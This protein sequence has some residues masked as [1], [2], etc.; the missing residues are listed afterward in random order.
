MFKSITSC[1]LIA[2]AILS[3]T[4]VAAIPAV[5][6]SSPTPT[7]DRP[8]STSQIP[9][10]SQSTDIRSTDRAFQSLQTLVERYGC[11][12]DLNGD[13]S[14]SRD[15][16]VT[17]LNVC[18]NQIER[19]IITNRNSVQPAD[20][21][22]LR[23][24]QTEFGTELAALRDRLDAVEKKTE[25]L[26]RQQFSPTT[27]FQGIVV[28]A[29]NA[30]S[31]TGDRILDINGNQ[32]TNSQ[33][34]ATVLYRAS[35]LFDTSFTGTDSLRIW[36]E[37]GSEGIG[38]NAAGLLEPT[39]G[40]VL[41]YSAK[42]PTGNTLGLSRVLYTF[43]PSP[44]L[45]V[46]AGPV[47]TLTDF[48]DRNSYANTSFQ[49]F[50][51]LALVNNFVLFPVGGLGAGGAIKWKPGNNA[52]TLSAGYVAAEAQNPGD[53]GPVRAA[54]AISQVLYPTS[55]GDSG[56]FGDT[57]QGVVELEYAPSKNLAVR[58]QYAGGQVLDNR[59]SAIGANLEWTLTPGLGL[60]G[61]YGYSWYDNTAFGNLNPQSWMAGV[62]FK[63]V[64]T[65]GAF[66]GLAVGQPF[67]ERNVG[68]VTQTNFEAFYNFPVNDSL[69][70][71]PV[72]QVITNPGNQSGNGTI[73][74]GTIRTVF[75]F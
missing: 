63:D 66:A 43:K 49:D 54:N 57:A 15:E 16:F 21:E 48:F 6:Q 42:P 3:A 62:M 10:L 52:V 72:M 41:D 34:N 2:G 11:E 70:I 36:L 46:S 73:F 7:F 45:E 25:K 4:V 29:A 19:R 56:L 18:I 33:P 32:I 60:F 59:F 30:G 65:P 55:R 68:T 8:S 20:L 39:L 1:A 12:I 28:M 37:A 61:R 51:T 17:G 67:V 26:E 53:R 38:D 24:L 22:I 27:K 31:F 64:F 50:S 44:D 14:L 9:A 47:I 35:L 74:T 69:R 13:R 40:S 71:S 5:G 75:S 58:L 23:Q